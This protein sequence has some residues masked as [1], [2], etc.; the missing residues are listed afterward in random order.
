MVPQS[1]IRGHRYKLNH[2]RA[3]TDVQKRVFAI[4]CVGPWNAL[5]DEVVSGENICSFKKKKNTNVLGDALFK[6]KGRVSKTK[7]IYLFVL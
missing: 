4:C 1:G 7:V 5:P 6:H 2:I 3:A